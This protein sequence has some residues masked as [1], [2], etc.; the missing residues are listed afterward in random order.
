MNYF[1][2]ILCNYYNKIISIN[3]ALTLVP[4]LYLNNNLNYY[5]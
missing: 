4:D 3:I 1:D 2:K 5:S